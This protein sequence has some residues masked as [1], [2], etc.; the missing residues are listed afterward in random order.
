MEAGSKATDLDFEAA[1]FTASGVRHRWRLPVLWL[2]AVAVGVAVWSLSLV[3]VS[4]PTPLRLDPDS[5]RLAAVVA[6]PEAL[7]ATWNSEPIVT[8]G[9]VQENGHRYF[10]NNSMCGFL[11][12]SVD[13]HGGYFATRA[14]GNQQDGQ[15]EF[16]ASIMRRALWLV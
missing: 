1:G 2:F 12:A 9:L 13:S 7:G 15:R 8:G 3:D 10:W 4:G 14:E 16:M 5:G 6:R 11:A